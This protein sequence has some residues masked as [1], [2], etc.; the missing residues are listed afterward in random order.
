MKAHAMKRY[1]DLPPC[2]ILNC[3][4]CMPNQ[5]NF[6]YPTIK[7]EGTPTKTWIIWDNPRQYKFSRRMNENVADNRINVL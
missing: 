7:N 2:K 4:S 5:P 6:S 1:E 3:P